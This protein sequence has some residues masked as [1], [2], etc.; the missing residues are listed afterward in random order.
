MKMYFNNE[1]GER[2]EILARV[3]DE[4]MLLQTMNGNYVVA[5]WIRGNSWG[6]GRY[7]MTDRSKAWKDFFELA[8]EAIGENMSYNEF[9]EMF[10]EVK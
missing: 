6:A 10:R 5:R 4:V 9:I 2:Y 1:N 3:R 8:Y 7:W